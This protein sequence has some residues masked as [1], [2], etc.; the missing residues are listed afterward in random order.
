MLNRRLFLGGLLVGA[1]SP[2]IVQ[3]QSLMKIRQVTLS[4]LF[5]VAFGSASRGDKSFHLLH[6]QEE[7]FRVMCDTFL[8][9]NPAG[10]RTGR[11]SSNGSYLSNRSKF[12]LQA[13]AKTPLHSML[14]PYYDA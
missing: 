8:A 5:G 10:P 12:E 4:P 3:A 1:T 14:V 6:R 13:N 2:S 11:F 7:N 9:W